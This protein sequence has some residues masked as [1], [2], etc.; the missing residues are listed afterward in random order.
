[1]EFENRV[2]VV[3]GAAGGIG[4]ATAQAFA[5]QGATVVL[6]DINETAVHEAASSIEKSGSE[7]LAIRAD[8]ADI[9]SVKAMVEQTVSRF[10]GVDVLVNNAANLTLAQADEGVLD[11]DFDLWDQMYRINLRGCIAACKF[12]IPHMLE[13]GRGAIINVSSAAAL[14]GD[15]R[16][17]AYGATKAGLDLATKSIATTFG[18]QGIRCNG[19]SPGTIMA[20]STR[21]AARPDLL[22]VQLAN[23]LLPDIGRPEQIADVITFVASDRAS[24]LTG[25]IIGVDGG[26]MA[27]MPWHASFN[28]LSDQSGR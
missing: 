10:G 17:V 20:E 8:V 1:M 18:K 5:E 21:D 16:R 23:V 2:A 4:L 25:Q 11:A 7:A 12:A 19:V 27:H 26:L 15:I 22:D 24:F 14:N 6:A 28:R 9:D 3:T 13:G